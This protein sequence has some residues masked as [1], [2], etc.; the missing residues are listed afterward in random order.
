MQEKIPNVELFK[1]YLNAWL[2]YAKLDAVEKL[3][4]IISAILLALILV[5]LSVCAMFYLSLA[6]VLWYSEVFGS[7]VMGVF[8]I[9]LCIVF[10]SLLLYLFRIKLLLNPLI[11]LF[12]KILFEPQ[13]TEEEGRINEHK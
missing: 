6:F 7:I 9:F 8:I 5:L 10:L 2:T 13:L 11:R 1:S 4:R 12:S 3:S